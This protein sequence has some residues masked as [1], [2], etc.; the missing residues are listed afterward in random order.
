MRATCPT[1]THARTHARTHCLTHAHAHARAHTRAQHTHHTHSPQALE[2]RVG[3]ILMR[4]EREL[5]DAEKTIGERLHV[6]DLDNDGL[7]SPEEL[8]EVIRGRSG[9]QIWGLG[10]IFRV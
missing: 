3:G 1:H 5:D 8:E 6:I 9:A 10:F 4:I 7:I 2:E